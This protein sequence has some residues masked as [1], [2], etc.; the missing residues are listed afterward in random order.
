M[1]LYSARLL[2]IVSNDLK[3]K[4][5]IWV[6][7]TDYVCTIF[8]FVYDHLIAIGIRTAT[9]I[10]F[11]VCYSYCCSS[12]HIVCIIWTI[13]VAVFV[14]LLFYHLTCTYYC[15][16]HSWTILCFI[17]HLIYTSYKVLESIY[18][19]LRYESVDTVHIAG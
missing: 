5:Y 7:P 15:M 14:F 13:S 8:F 17:C 11:I 2:Q 12:F 3:R 6:C 16:Y 18:C 10:V 19:G 1:V 9:N 4:I